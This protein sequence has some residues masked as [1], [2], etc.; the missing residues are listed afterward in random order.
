MCACVYVYVS[1]TPRCVRP[2][3]VPQS[4]HCIVEWTEQGRPS[5]WIG[6][7][8]KISTVLLLFAPLERGCNAKNIEQCTL[9]ACHTS[10]LFIYSCGLFTIRWCTFLCVR[11]ALYV[12]RDLCTRN[13]ITYSNKL[14][15][16][17]AVTVCACVRMCVCMFKMKFI[18][19]RERNVCMS[20]TK[21]N[22]NQPKSNADAI[23][24]M[25]E[26]C[27]ISSSLQLDLYRFA[28]LALPFIYMEI[29]IYEKSAREFDK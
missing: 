27:S 23:R 24:W 14:E 19:E 17:C 2:M 1:F 21:F 10:L 12:C 8:E 6:K 28:T 11:S 15:W 9:K 13:C 20:F 4:K 22:D 7:M 29:E 5:E 3:W 25:I 18:I 26:C 16:N